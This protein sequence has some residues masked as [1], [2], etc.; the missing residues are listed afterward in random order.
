MR[1]PWALALLF[2]ML[3]LSDVARADAQTT[4]VIRNQGARPVRVQVSL[5]RVLPCDSADNQMLLDTTLGGGE[6]R[7]FGMGS[8]GTACVRNTSPGSTLDWSTSRWLSGGYRCRP[9]RLCVRDPSVLM[10]F[11]VGG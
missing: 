3:C 1:N 11:D 2:L 4:M 5:G 9:R 6:V 8:A 7:T 10:R